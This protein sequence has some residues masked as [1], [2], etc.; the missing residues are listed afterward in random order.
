MLTSSQE[1][2]PRSVTPMEEDVLCAVHHDEPRPQTV[3][4]SSVLHSCD[5]VRRSS[6]RRRSGR[7]LKGKGQTEERIKPENSVRT[8]ELQQKNTSLIMKERGSWKNHEEITDMWPADKTVR[9]CKRKLEL[10][11]IT[12]ESHVL[13][14]SSTVQEHSRSSLDMD[15]KCP[16]SPPPAKRWVIG[17]LLQSFK[18]KMAS[19]TEIV[20]SPVRLFKPTD[21][22]LSNAL[23]SHCEQLAGSNKESSSISKEQQP[24]V[25]RDVTKDLFSKEET[26]CPPSKI[27]IVVERL[28]FNTNLSN[29]SDSDENKALV[30]PST[31]DIQRNGV[32]CLLQSIQ[33]GHGSLNSS[34]ARDLS[35][36]VEQP[37]GPSNEYQNKVYNATSVSEQSGSK[38]SQEK[39][40]FSDPRLLTDTPDTIDLKLARVEVPCPNTSCSLSLT[41]NTNRKGLMDSEESFLRMPIRTSPRKM[42]KLPLDSN[43]LTPLRSAKKV[44]VTLSEQNILV[45]ATK[46][47]EYTHNNKARIQP[48]S[49]DDG[50]PPLGCEK[51][52]R[53]TVPKIE[54]VRCLEKDKLVKKVK[55]CSGRT[56]IKNKANFEQEFPASILARVP[57]NE[58]SIQI[59]KRRK[60][61]VSGNLTLSSRDGVE[62]MSFASEMSGSCESPERDKIG[63]ER[64]S[65]S[66]SRRDGKC[67]TPATLGIENDTIG[68]LSSSD[69]SKSALVDSCLQGNGTSGMG[70]SDCNDSN[71]VEAR[72]SLRSRGMV[73]VGGS[74]KS[75]KSWNARQRKTACHF[76][77]GVSLGS[78]TEQPGEPWA[79]NGHRDLEEASNATDQE[80]AKFA[81]KNNVCQ[82]KNKLDASA[83]ASVLSSSKK[84]LVHVKR[85]ESRE[86]KDIDAV[87]EPR[88][89]MSLTLQ[90]GTKTDE[91]KGSVTLLPVQTGSTSQWQ[92]GRPIENCRTTRGMG[93]WGTPAKEINTSKT[94]LV[95][96]K[97]QSFIDKE[98]GQLGKAKEKKKSKV[99]RPRRKCISLL[100]K[101]DAR[102]DEEQTRNQTEEA[103]PV[104]SSSGSGSSRLLRSFSC[105]DIPSLLHGDNVPL[106]PLHDQIP[107]SPPKKFCPAP[108]DAHHPHS[109]S[110]RARRHTV[111]SVEIEREIAPRCLR[112]EVHPTGWSSASNHVY[113]HSHSSSLTALA[114]CFLSS[115]LAFL[116]KKSSQGRSDDDVDLASTSPR[117]F[118]KSPS[119]SFLKSPTSPTLTANPA[120]FASVPPTPEQSSASVSSPCSVFEP[121]P[122]EA[123]VVQREREEDSQSSFSLKLSSRSISEE[124]AL[125][126]SE[127]KTDDKREE[128]RKVSSIRIRKTLPKPQY[129][130]TPMGLPKAIRIKKKVF[131]VEE[132]YTNKNFSKPPEGRFETI[133]EVPQSRQD[134]SQ[135]LFGQKR[136]KRFIEFPELGVPRKPRKPRKP[137]V[138]GAGV[139]GAQRKAA[140]NS[141]IGRTRR[142]VWAS[143]RDEDALNLQDLD[144]LLCSKL[145]ELD[146]WM[147]L[148]QLAY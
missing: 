112:K 91:Q 108:P 72:P 6:S 60:V 125:S 83:V 96:F 98:L 5:E 73:T 146:S 109:P 50:V 136:M 36:H 92:A 10:P 28:N 94:A 29:E 46:V 86:V 18:S 34:S 63:Q 119:P 90:V 51:K 8:P 11:S 105:P 71:P 106:A 142:G 62:M 110:K 61:Q 3:H 1:R 95:H 40:R 97:D 116:S 21:S 100:R 20:M 42:S 115:P 52:P 23:T 41:K 133:F 17:P 129:N 141:G 88:V 16:E 76:E 137:L 45:G 2:V 39:S 120:F 27:S 127:I 37:M 33:E 117:S 77:S 38:S 68:S 47:S 144:S 82:A 24:D 121:V 15:P 104:V 25:E 30:S 13:K 147:A 74:V 9:S 80:Q 59:G 14:N 48:F 69:A 134:S 54:L 140:G 55:S 58:T 132:I 67:R 101:K 32:Q 139:G 31:S 26:V 85:L 123:D 19:F 145:N 70:A 131:T 22:S 138:G 84:P 44:S 78:S 148:E 118:V 43:R 113:P 124:R 111:C 64:V 135:S 107:P 99:G 35:C 79:K 122:V 143:S 56:K 49:K 114:S 53:K 130:L 66:R 126:D 12:S 93:K 87:E 7:L 81:Q 75:V 89:S 57:V 128:R 103:I 65:R 4:R 102:D